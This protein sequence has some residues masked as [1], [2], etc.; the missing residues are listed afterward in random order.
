MSSSSGRHPPR[1]YGDGM[2]NLFMP[3]PSTP[4][5]K[6]KPP[7][8]AASAPT[9]QQGGS[10]RSL[11]A[12]DILRER[13]TTDWMECRSQ[14][15][16]RWRELASSLSVR[17]RVEVETRDRGASAVAPWRC[18]GSMRSSS[19]IVDA[20]STHRRWPRT[21]RDFLE[22]H[23]HQFRVSRRGP[24][25]VLVYLLTWLTTCRPPWTTPPSQRLC[26]IHIYRPCF[27]IPRSH[28]P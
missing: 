14:L 17:L 16:P 21:S 15:T 23:G 24:A 2:V 12:G 5:A 6:S 20:R 18:A 27:V 7:C 26:G 3:T 19:S 9:H 22:P 13:C 28:A 1:T 8:R 11:V 25:M 10:W 4:S